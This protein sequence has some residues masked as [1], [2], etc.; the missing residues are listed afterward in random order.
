VPSANL[1]DTL[2]SSLARSL[3]CLLDHLLRSFPETTFIQHPDPEL[4]IARCEA[5]MPQWPEMDGSA[6]CF[7]GSVRLNISIRSRDSRTS[8]WIE[9]LS[10]GSVLQS[11]C[12]SSVDSGFETLR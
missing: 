4:V 12:R 2:V 7:R 11:P 5:S 3:A 10:F 6:L 1:S 8:L 9:Q